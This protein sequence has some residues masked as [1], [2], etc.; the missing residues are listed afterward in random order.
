ML[1]FFH[2]TATSE[3]YTY[4][5]TLSLHAALPYSRPTMLVMTLVSTRPLMYSA[6]V[7]GDANTLRKFRDHTSSKNAVVTPCI[8]RLKKSHSSTAPS[9]VGT[10]SMPDGPTLFR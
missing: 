10:K 2:D 5:H 1:F 4:C 8:T 7:S 3:I 6:I 9:S